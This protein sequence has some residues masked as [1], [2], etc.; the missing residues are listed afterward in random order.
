MHKEIIILGPQNLLNTNLLIK[1]DDDKYSKA[2][3]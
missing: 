3:D 2:Y 1:L